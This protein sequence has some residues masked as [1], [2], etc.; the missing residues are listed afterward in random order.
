MPQSSQLQHLLSLN[1]T[2]YAFGFNLYNLHKN[3]G[4]ICSESGASQAKVTLHTGDGTPFDVIYK[5]GSLFIDS[6]KG[7]QEVNDIIAPYIAEYG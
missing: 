3:L 5:E 6:A 2:E 7:F 4:S 1:E